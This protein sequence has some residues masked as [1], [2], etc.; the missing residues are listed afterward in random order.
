MMVVVVVVVVVMVMVVLV[1]VVVVLGM[2]VDEHLADGG[3][4]LV[5]MNANFFPG[6]GWDRTDLLAVSIGPGACG[7]MRQAGRQPVS[8]LPI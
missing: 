3:V 8:Q 1:E 5:L 7:S 2:V 4:L 6:L